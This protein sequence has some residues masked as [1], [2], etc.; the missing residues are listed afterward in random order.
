MK[1]LKFYH[2]KY[3]EKNLKKKTHILST[4]VNIYS[5]I[6]RNNFQKLNHMPIEYEKSFFNPKGRYIY[7]YIHHSYQLITASLPIAHHLLPKKAVEFHFLC[8]GSFQEQD[9]SRW[10]IAATIY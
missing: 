7:I 4:S 9:F 8:E 5:Y 10:S 2:L 1:E 3:S 6:I